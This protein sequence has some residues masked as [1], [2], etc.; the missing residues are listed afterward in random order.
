M[1]KFY[2]LLTSIFYSFSLLAG[3]WYI[4]YMHDSPKSYII[5]GLISSVYYEDPNP[6]YQTKVYDNYKNADIYDIYDADIE[7]LELKFIE[8]GIDKLLIQEVLEKLN[9]VDRLSYDYFKKELLVY[10]SEYKPKAKNGFGAGRTIDK[11]FSLD[12]PISFNHLLYSK[13]S[14]VKATPYFEYLIYKSL[15]HNKNSSSYSE[16]RL[17]YERL[18]EKYKQSDDQFLKNKYASLLIRL[19][20][21][22][23]ESKTFFLEN[24]NPSQCKE[25]IAL[26]DFAGYFYH[27]S[28]KEEKHI[29]KS[30]YY[31][32][33]LGKN[34]KLIF[35]AFREINYVLSSSWNYKFSWSD[36]LDLCLNEQE[37][38]NLLFIMSNRFNG[39]NVSILETFAELT[40]VNS[41]H[42]ESL[43]INYVKRLVHVGVKEES[44]DK[45]DACSKCIEAYEFY[46]FIND[47]KLSNKPLL[48]FLRGYTAF[49]VN[50]IKAYKSNF[51]KCRSSIK[52]SSLNNLEQQNFML[53]LE[54]IELMDNLNRCSSLK[55][56]QKLKTK[57]IVHINNTP[58]N[59]RHDSYFDVGVKKAI[60]F[61]D[62]VSA[63][64]FTESQGYTQSILLDVYMSDEEIRRLYKIVENGQLNFSYR[65]DKNLD[66]YLIEL[67]GVKEFRKNNINNAISYFKKTEK[68]EVSEEYAVLIQ[69]QLEKIQSIK[70][71][72]ISE[73]QK[74]DLLSPC[75]LRIA[76][77]YSN[78]EWMYFSFW[79][80]SLIYGLAYVD[81][82]PFNV[83]EG[84]F[85]KRKLILFL[86]EYGSL[87]K[88]IK[89]YEKVVN[90]SNDDEM[91]AE[92]SYQLL[93]LYKKPYLTTF[94]S[95]IFNDY[96]RGIIDSAYINNLPDSLKFVYEDQY[97][98]TAKQIDSLYQHTNYFNDVI[99]ECGK[100]YTQPLLK[101]NDNFIDIISNGLKKNDLDES[102]GVENNKERFI[103][104]LLT[105][106]V[107]I[108]I[109]MKW[110]T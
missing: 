96:Y 24:F 46:A 85:I 54:G 1:K 14:Q 36:C 74:S 11:K 42:F 84:D 99:G 5:P 4:P 29:E 23:E 13:F 55:E 75:Y 40:N 52:T 88:S 58:F 65:F 67:L 37:R 63:F 97:I 7:Q 93:K 70:S 83:L 69:E 76:Q 20:I 86:N 17:L 18:V 27:A 107:V 87:K 8:L 44:C 39:V 56:F 66:K 26:S 28:K 72:N 101:S 10:Y 100:L 91:K 62:F 80:G 103:I 22:S 19:N 104:F 77:L 6:R 41:P 102:T 108:F 33:L 68:V 90:E 35:N 49:L 21:F 94:H 64:E 89:F 50:D 45:K 106:F 16:R 31:F 110:R 53:Q 43:L 34:P 82:G 61:K 48:Y 30:V 15:I 98:K 95:G 79:H 59:L 38:E 57:L 92:A 3:G 32:S 105:I 2:L 73:D 25:Y 109:F 9:D 47:L 51:Y 60:E 71:S 78:Y 12:N 81:Y